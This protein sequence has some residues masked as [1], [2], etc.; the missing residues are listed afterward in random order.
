MTKDQERKQLEKIAALIQEAG[1]DSYIGMAFAGCVECA[2]ENIANDWGCSPLDRAEAAEKKLDALRADLQKEKD[3]TGA[4]SGRIDGLK[5]QLRAA[6]DLQKRTAEARDEWKRAYNAA[7]EAANTADAELDTLK[8][9]VMKL[10]ARLYD[11]L[12]KD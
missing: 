8:Q 4:L 1:A 9:E 12:V 11:L 2:E 10:K 6:D 5:D 7:Q 3:L